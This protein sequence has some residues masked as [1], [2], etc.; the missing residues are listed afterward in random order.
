MVI[1]C[2]HGVKLK[3]GE[4]FDPNR[5]YYSHVIY[6]DNDGSTWHVGGTV[7]RGGTNE[8]QIAE[9]SDGSLYLSMRNYDGSLRRAWF[10]M[11]RSE[12]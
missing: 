7:P 12:D 1:P 10:V 3:P 11:G 5:H 6:S 8:C 4:D 9:L 2:N